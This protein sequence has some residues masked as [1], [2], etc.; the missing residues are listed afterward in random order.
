MDDISKNILTLPSLDT[1]QHNFSFMK[2]QFSYD[3]E[4]HKEDSVNLHFMPSPE[5][6]EL[7]RQIEI[8]YRTKII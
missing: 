6:T 4:K 5:N 2:L 1:L 7:R 3:F 8:K